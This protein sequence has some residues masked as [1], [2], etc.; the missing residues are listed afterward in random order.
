MTAP[1][2]VTRISDPAIHNITAVPGLTPK[3]DQQMAATVKFWLDSFV[4][5]IAIAFGGIDIFGW[6][7]FEFLVD[8]G[9]ERIAEA[10]ANYIA[11]TTAQGSANFANS[12]IAVFLTERIAT[13]VTGGVALSTSFS[14]AA[15][16]TLGSDF[17]RR[18]LDVGAGGFGPNGSGVAVWTKSGGTGRIHLDRHN[19][20]L[21]TNY[22]VIRLVMTSLPEPPTS[23]N[24]AFNWLRGRIN[25]AQDTYVAAVIGYNS[26][27]IGCRV[28]DTDT[29]FDTVA[30]TPQV[31]DT[32]LLYIGTSTDDYELILKQNSV[33]RWQDIDSSHVS[34]IGASYRYPGLG[35]SAGAGFG[36][37][38]Q[39]APGSLDAWAAADRLPT[40]V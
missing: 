8:W 2:Y 12:Q 31:G 16:S 27:T 9:N 35:A 39:V 37:F 15:S 17:T 22:Q 23:G 28:S 29:I 10:Q 18:S 19:T 24:Q 20:P 21:A 36:F 26:F 1:D 6:K 11:A 32:W 4:G 7:P 3:T 33:I 14:T 38:T 5:Q 34:Q 25:A 40:T 13:D 30:V